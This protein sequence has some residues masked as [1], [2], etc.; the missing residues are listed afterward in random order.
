L[1]YVLLLL[2]KKK[3]RVLRTTAVAEMQA[4]K[5]KN[6]IPN[7]K[8]LERCYGQDLR[9]LCYTTTAVSPIAFR[10]PVFQVWISASVSSLAL[11]S[12][13]PARG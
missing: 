7:L 6:T 12:N 10:I 13:T 11:H 4:R 2:E 8:D 3:H 5:Q 1:S 9:K